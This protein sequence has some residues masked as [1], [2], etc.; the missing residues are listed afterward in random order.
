[1]LRKYPLAVIFKI[2]GEQYSIALRNTQLVSNQV[3]KFK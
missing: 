3:V 1:M 2:I